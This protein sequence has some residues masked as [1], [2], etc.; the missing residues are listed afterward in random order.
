MGED[1]LLVSAR[2]RWPDE[3]TFP[4]RFDAVYPIRQIEYLLIDC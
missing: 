3:R 2:S 4:T 1:R